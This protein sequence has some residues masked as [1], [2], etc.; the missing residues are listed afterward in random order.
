MDIS[1]EKMECLCPPIKKTGEQFTGEE[2]MQMRHQRR[3][4][5]ASTWGFF[6]AQPGNTDTWQITE[7]IGE[8]AE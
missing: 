1:K 2:K 5:G 7:H 4:H 3:Q 8:D 6:F